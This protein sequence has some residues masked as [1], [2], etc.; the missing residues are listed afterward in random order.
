MSNREDVIIVGG[1]AVGLSVAYHLGAQKQHS[2]RLFEKNQ[3]GSGTSWH[4]AGIVGPLRSSLNMTRLAMHA[5]ELF[6]RL[7]QETGQSIGYRRTGGY[8]LVQTAERLT[9]LRRICAVG[10]AVGLDTQIVSPSE[11]SR[12]IDFIRADDLTGA[13]WVG[14]DAQV[15]PVDLC[16][17]Y[18]IG[19]K[20]RGVTIEDSCGVDKFIVEHDAVKGVV[21][22]D[23]R[24]YFAD[25]VV[26]CAG[27]WSRE[28]A[29]TAG[30]RVPL[31][32]VEHMYIVTE[33][34]NC[35]PD[36]VPVIRDL[37]SDIYLKGDTGKLVLGGFERNAK[38]WNPDSS[39]PHIP[40]V[41][42]DEDWSH[43]EPI[44]SAG[45]N[46]VPALG[47][48]GVHT[49]MNGPES[50]TPDTRPMIGESAQVAGFYVA[51]GFNSVG[52]MS[53]AG[54][55]HALARWILDGA[56][57]YDLWEVDVA[58]ADPRW[59]EPHFLKQRMREAVNDQFAM[60]WPLK[61]PQYG[62]DMR[63]TP[64]HGLLQGKGA[65][66]GSMAGWERPLWFAHSRQE[67]KL[68]HT[69]SEQPWWR[70]VAREARQ[71][72][73]AVTLTD[74]TPFTKIELRGAGSVDAL[75]FLCAADVDIKPGG[76]RYTVMLNERGGI[77]ADVTVLRHDE[78]HFRIISAAAIR[79]RDLRRMRRMLKGYPSVSMDDVTTTEAVIGVMGP[80][81]RKLMECVTDEDC[82]G[83]SFRF[84]TSR[85][86]RIADTPVAALR[87]SYVGELGW[88]IYVGR[89]FAAQVYER[90][91]AAGRDLGIGQLG[92]LAVD[93][94]RLEKRFGHWGHDWGPDVTPLEAGLVHA[95]NMQKS[96]FLG[97]E[98]L[99]RQIHAGLRQRLVLLEVLIE[100]G[101]RPLLLHDEPVVVEDEMIGLTTS[102][103]YGPRTGKLLSFALIRCGPDESL[104]QIHDRVVTIEIAGV[105]HVARVCPEAPYDPDGMRM[106]G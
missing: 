76:S 8:W 45:L 47:S 63:C 66:F 19:A 38:T 53:S 56:P 77:E 80:Q 18:A 74:F 46:R 28:L 92:L 52:V 88:E 43:F 81:S 20:S 96:D 70:Y 13:M 85:H 48:T 78:D 98:A 42:F 23:G 99:Q 73:D 82:S 6:P 62:R 50:F 91:L 86:M 102:G 60:H 75:Q 49:F 55:G 90:F 61:Q 30:V 97:R 100:S 15:S 4:A 36:P 41:M 105:S 35:L 5:V 33:T 37:D 24:R 22:E 51:A 58:R 1:G 101:E 3:I 57:P 54:V 103:G 40:F 59:S 2:V 94:C 79:Y 64:L 87:R 44:M 68:I 34:M 27:L 11:L 17:A 67:E 83:E 12:A 14:E 32:A 95:V 39:G 29:A 71:M 7:E 25:R 65:V 104:A 21:L 69:Y 72:K 26:L 16:S 89:E 10:T 93:G 31:Q 84:G 106:R 9:E